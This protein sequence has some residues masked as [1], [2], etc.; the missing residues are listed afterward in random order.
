MTEHYYHARTDCERLQ[1][2]AFRKI[3]R[4]ECYAI[5]WV[6]DAANAMKHVKPDRKGSR[7]GYGDIETY[8]LNVCGTA[9]CGFP[10]GGHEVLLGPERAWR[11]GEVIKVAV[12]FWRGKL[13]V[14]V[15]SS[16]S[17]NTK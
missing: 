12:A 11:L 8:R 10:M 3:L 6:E 16:A 17:V 7:W 1:L 5:G 2:S 14:A 13:G 9:R 15:D 4:D